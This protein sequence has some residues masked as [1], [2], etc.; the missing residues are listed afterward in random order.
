[1]TIITDYTP[2]DQ[3]P[4]WIAERYGWHNLSD[5]QWATIRDDLALQQRGL[6]QQEHLVANLNS[7]LASHMQF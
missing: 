7:F 1:M 4:S 3:L 6:D 2:T 5:V